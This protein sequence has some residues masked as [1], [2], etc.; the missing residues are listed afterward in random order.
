MGIRP[1]PSPTISSNKAPLYVSYRIN[2]R[3]PI[4][5][6]VTSIQGTQVLGVYFAPESGSD[7]FN[8]NGELT[9]DGTDSSKYSGSI[10]YVPKS[11]T[12]PYS[13]YWGVG[14]SSIPYDSIPLSLSAVNAIVDT[15]TT[16]HL[17][18]YLRL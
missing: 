9:L 5:V 4:N 8:Q 1:L 10:S 13:Y 17:H 14:V 7:T 3:S 6:F 16:P 2:L 12:S 15:G 18:P 11:T